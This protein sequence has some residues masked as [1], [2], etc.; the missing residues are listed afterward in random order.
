[1]RL[2]RFE[3]TGY[4][5]L[6][7]TVALDGLGGFEVIHGEN[8]VGKSNLLQ[9]IDLFFVLLASV[10]K[11]GAG[12]V[13]NVGEDDTSAAFLMREG[14]A[15]G[16][17]F[18]MPEG[19]LSQ[20]GFAPDDIFNFEEPVPI[21]LRGEIEATRADWGRAGIPTVAA[22]VFR[23]SFRLTRAH[24]ASV[25]VEVHGPPQ[26][27]DE[28]WWTTFR[29]F[30]GLV[31]SNFNVRSD[32]NARGF[33]LVD[34]LRR[35]AGVDGNSYANDLRRPLP[36]ELALGL[37]DAKE[38][39]EP[40]L[41]ERW[42]LFESAMNSLTH[43]VGEGRVVI[44]Y[45]RSRGTA[46]LA[47]QKGR[48]RVPID[49]MGSGVQQLASLIA[50][51]LLANSA[52]VAIEEPELHLRYEMQL[53]LGEMLRAIVSK[54]LGPQQIIV[55][56][57]SP[58]FEAG[59]TFHAMRLSDAGPVV[60]RTPV[61]QALAFTQQAIQVQLPADHGAYG[62]VSSDGLFRLPDDIRKTLGVEHGGGVVVLKRAEHRYVEIMTDEE[63]LALLNEGGEL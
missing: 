24:R 16:V 46:L 49:S 28:A 57:H 53:R 52:I 39:V 44:T 26:V 35:V 5:N 48:L 50:R 62:Y 34:T 61:G 18:H 21:E 38:S 56:S 9:A 23:V 29:H 25:D 60:E 36:L 30:S 47:V 40:G 42:E 58:A 11:R 8:N 55:S 43:I 19:A 3:V 17:R 32:V 13:A 20:R 15:V 27:I 59:S 63:V 14:Q 1:M 37:Y 31:A 12:L 22:G 41:P 7:R 6:R 4:K 10:A 51:V 45:N 2:T 33:I 54:G